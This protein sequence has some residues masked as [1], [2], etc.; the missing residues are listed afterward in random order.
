MFL[1][2]YQL[3]KRT[4]KLN[5]TMSQLKE[6]ENNYKDTQLEN[7]KLRQNATEQEMAIIK[8]ELQSTFFFFF[9]LFYFILYV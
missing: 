7:K 8:K 9:F 1:F 6:V 4:N 2:L 5:E 3:D